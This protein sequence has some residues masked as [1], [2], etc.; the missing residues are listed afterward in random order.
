[1]SVPSQ[2]GRVTKFWLI[3]CALIAAE[4]VAILDT[5]MSIQLVY[6]PEGFFDVPLSTLTWIVTAY[7]LAAAIFAGIGARL[8]DQYGRRRILIGALALGAV[9]R[10]CRQ[11]LPCSGCSSS[12]ASSKA[13]P[14]AFCRLRWASYP[15]AI[16]RS[17]RELP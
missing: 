9:G 2:N 15:H 13:S 10:C 1:M 11:S 6:A 12:D 8:G 3:T 4:G 5:T 16:R 17:A 14:D 7:T